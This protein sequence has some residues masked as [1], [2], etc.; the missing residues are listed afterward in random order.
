MLLRYV[1]T[2]SSNSTAVKL[3]VM[4]LQLIKFWFSSENETRSIKKTFWFHQI[5]FNF[6]QLWRVVISS[7]RIIL[8]KKS[9]A[10]KNRS[11]HQRCFT[12]ARV[13]RLWHKCFPVKFLKTPFLQNASGRLLLKENCEFCFCVSLNS[14]VVWV[15]CCVF[16]YS[17][18]FCYKSFLVAS[19]F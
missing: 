14:L 5:F 12:C 7:F 13:S 4:K 11:S 2:K 18:N 15:F 17:N 10:T 8:L 3:L 16:S 19:F 9:I 1:V 6:F